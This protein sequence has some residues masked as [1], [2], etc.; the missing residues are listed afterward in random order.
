MVQEVKNSNATILQALAAAP[1]T[2]KTPTA[3][4]Q[5]SSLTSKPAINAAMDQ[6]IQ[7]EMLKILQK[8]DNKLDNPTTTQPL[9]PNIDSKPTSPS[10]PGLMECVLITAKIAIP[11][12]RAIKMQLH[13]QTRWEAA[14]LIVNKN[15]MEAQKIAYFYY[16][17]LLIK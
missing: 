14:Q 12:M 17:N 3:S 13:L 4:T 11:N 7:L 16:K 15:E 6:N 9:P 2:C 10:T 5:A 1:Q 8:I